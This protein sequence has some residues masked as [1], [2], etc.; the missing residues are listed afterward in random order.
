MIEKHH[1][2]SMFSRS[3]SPMIC[4]ASSENTSSRSGISSRVHSLQRW[5]IYAVG[6]GNVK[7]IFGGECVGNESICGD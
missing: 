6:E 5:N 1:L 4:K 3:Q 7:Y 2:N